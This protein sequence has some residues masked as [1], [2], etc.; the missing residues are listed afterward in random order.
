MTSDTFEVFFSYA[1]ADAALAD[2]LIAALERAEVKVSRDTR[3]IDDFANIQRVIAEGL[4][5]STVLLE[6]YSQAYT[7]QRIC[8][9]E[10]ATAV[11]AGGI[12]RVMAVNPEKSVG[13]THPKSLRTHPR[14]RRD[15]RPSQI[16]AHD[17]ERC[18]GLRD[19]TQLQAAPDRL[20]TKLGY[21]LS[22]RTVSRRLKASWIQRWMAA[23]SIDQL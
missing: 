21:E 10:L 18:K 1:S 12:E 15:V 11:V 9:R 3:Q 13:H 22:G 23:V 17:R 19:H 5:R 8:D 4:A 7:Q 20:F 16:P 6:F 14:V 2:P